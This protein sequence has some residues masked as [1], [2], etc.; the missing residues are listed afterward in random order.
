MKARKCESMDTLVKPHL[1]GNIQS[2]CTVFSTGCGPVFPMEYLLPKI[3]L[4]ARV[5]GVFAL[6]GGFIG[7][8]GAVELGEPLIFLCT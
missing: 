8:F 2:G 7:V 3:L 4:T 5:R 6:D 1:Q